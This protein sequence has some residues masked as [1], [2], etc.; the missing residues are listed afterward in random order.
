MI[1]RF[2][3]F[4]HHTWDV[5]DALHLADQDWTKYHG[6]G[7]GDHES[8]TDASIRNLVRFHCGNGHLKRLGV[9]KAQF[10]FSHDSSQ[11]LPR[12]K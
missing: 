2:V 5:A 11:R 6:D 3:E 9:R 4:G 10:S 8:Q 1:D 7:S 12:M